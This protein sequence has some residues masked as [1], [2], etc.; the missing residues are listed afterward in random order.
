MDFVCKKVLMKNLGGKCLVE[1]LG[2]SAIFD[3]LEPPAFKQFSIHW[4]YIVFVFVSVC[5]CASLSFDF[6]FCKS[7]SW[8]LSSPNDKLLENIWFVWSRTS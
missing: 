2:E 8:S 5:V 4:E 3:I 7:W 6:S 1:N